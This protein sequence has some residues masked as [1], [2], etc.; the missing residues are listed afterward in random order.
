MMCPLPLHYAPWLVNCSGM[1]TAAKQTIIIA[2]QQNNKSRLFSPI[3]ARIS[4]QL[5]NRY[6]QQPIIILVLQITHHHMKKIYIL[7]I[8]IAPDSN[9]SL[10]GWYM[11]LFHHTANIHSSSS[12]PYGECRSCPVRADFFISSTMYVSLPAVGNACSSF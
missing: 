2:M 5:F 12:E 4:I 9:F 10:K 11:T 7:I 3:R 8:I 6:Q 1:K